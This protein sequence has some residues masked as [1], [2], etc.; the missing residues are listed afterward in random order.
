MASAD[1]YPRPTCSIT[2]C[3]LGSVSAASAGHSN[4]KTSD[5][6]MSEDLPHIT[7][8][9]RSLFSLWESPDMVAAEGQQGP[10]SREAFTCDSPVP[11]PS[12]RETSAAP[13]P[14]CRSVAASGTR[15]R[16]YTRPRRTSHPR[17][18]RVAAN[19]TTTPSFQAVPVL[20][21]QYRNRARTSDSG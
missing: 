1:R 6:D 3:R 7:L 8:T 2:V 20:S 16:A 17:Q 4:R 5:L 21:R 9:V 10:F 12:T 15:L 19:S 11:S 13:L 14:P 18:Q